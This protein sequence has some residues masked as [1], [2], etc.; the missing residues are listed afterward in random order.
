[1][2]LSAM[3]L[4]KPHR[5]FWLLVLVS[6]LIFACCKFNRNHYSIGDSF[7]SLLVSQALLEHASIKLDPYKARIPA[8]YQF[9]EKNGHIYYYFP[10]GT[11]IMAAPMIAIALATGNDTLENNHRLQA[12][13]AGVVNIALFLFLFLIARQFLDET[14]SLA[15]AAIFWFSTSLASVLG[16][17]LWSHDFAIL[18]ATI[19]LWLSCRPP[20]VSLKRAAALG[21]TLFMAYLCRPTLALLAPCICLYLLA[22][23]KFAATATTIVVLAACALL[24]IGFSQREFG[25]L[26]PDYYI[27]QRLSGESFSTALYANMLSPARG[28]LVYTPL[29]LILVINPIATITAIR[30]HASLW[31]ISMIWIL[32]HWISVSRFPHW[33]GGF[34]YGPRLMVDIL[35]AVFVMLIT[36]ISC[37]SPQS[38]NAYRRQTLILVAMVGCWMHVYQG[39]MNAYSG[40]LW[41]VKPNIDANPQLIFDWRYPQFLHNQERHEKRLQ[42]FEAS[43]PSKS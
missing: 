9:H 31:L 42:E 15:C 5:T 22:H 32:A 24:F 10:L 17:A 13:I 25:Q 35:P 19:S 6:A 16:T 39:L 30:R 1:M 23:R 28:L 21:I 20:A 4:K 36:S 2:K 11:S 3:P 18:F 29:L 33:W 41:N 7:G 34:S 27:P 40:V 37:W 43:S 12:K 26:L 14:A 8:G 38:W